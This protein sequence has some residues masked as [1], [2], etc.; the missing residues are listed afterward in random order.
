M[1]TPVFGDEDQRGF[2]A[3]PIGG[4]AANDPS[5]LGGEQEIVDGE[6]AVDVAV[7]I[8]NVPALLG[9]RRQNAQ[10]QQQDD[11][12][13][14]SGAGRSRRGRRP[15]TGGSAAQNLSDCSTSVLRHGC[16]PGRTREPVRRG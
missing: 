6:R 15:R 7:V 1:L 2:L 8:L 4:E 3:M 5:A 14:N 12:A 13:A 9:G 11:A 16:A 10:D